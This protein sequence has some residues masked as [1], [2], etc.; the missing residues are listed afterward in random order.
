MGNVDKHEDEYDAKFGKNED[1]SDESNESD[2]T[3]VTTF[4]WLGELFPNF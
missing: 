3:C 1:E 4:K 2:K